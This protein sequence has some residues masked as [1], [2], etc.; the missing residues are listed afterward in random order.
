MECGW[1][2]ET[3]RI[4]SERLRQEG[5]IHTYDWTIND[6]INSIDQL[7][8]IGKKE[9]DAVMS[10]NFIV[11]LFPAG[12][13]SHIELG[14]ALGN[15]IK[16]YLYAQNDDINDLETTSTFYHVDGV[17]KC[18]GTIEELIQNILKEQT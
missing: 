18:K 13:G 10:S 6:N 3:V 14:I 12:K 1:I 15:G 8:D 11:V 17:S 16:A 7:K 4:V 5:F 2:L 9:I